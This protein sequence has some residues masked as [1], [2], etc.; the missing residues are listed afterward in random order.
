[1]PH[2]W[3]QVLNP[4]QSLKTY[5]CNFAGMG[6]DL[7][8]NLIPY[9][10]RKNAKWPCYLEWIKLNFEKWHQMTAVCVVSLESFTCINSLILA[11]PFGATSQ[12]WLQIISVSITSP[13][14]VLLKDIGLYALVCCFGFRTFF[15]WWPGEVN[16]FLIDFTLPLW[17]L[18][19]HY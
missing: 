18:F 9:I 17:V 11:R 4:I 10:Q 16:F 8:F 1:M 13:F 14:C 7:S 6:W 2:P 19:V 12:N 3:K 5:I 15:C